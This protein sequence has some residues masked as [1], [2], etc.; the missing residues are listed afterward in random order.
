[1]KQKLMFSLCFAALL[2]SLPVNKVNA[3]EPDTSPFIDFYGELRYIAIFNNNPSLSISNYL[4]NIKSSV[5]II[6]DYNYEIITTLQKSTNK[7]SWTNVTQW[8]ETGAGNKNT[9]YSYTYTTAI[10]L[11]YQVSCTINI[12][13]NGRLIESNTET[14]PIIRCT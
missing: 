11:Y 2:I 3:L 5:Y 12:Y 6:G 7:T 13:S 10:N 4:A 14:S 1:M 9:T 8:I